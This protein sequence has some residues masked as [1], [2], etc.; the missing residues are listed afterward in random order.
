MPR[1]SSY[2]ED[3][4]DRLVRAAAERLVQAPPDQLSLRELAAS[5]DTSTNAIYSL[6]GGKDALIRAVVADANESFLAEQEKALE[7][8]ATI[9]G[10]ME[11]GRRYRAWALDQPSLY[12]LMFGGV[13]TLASIPC[14][15]IGP[16]EQMVSALVEAGVLRAAPVRSIGHALWAASHGFV[17][18]EMGLQIDREIGDEQFREFQELFLQGLLASSEEHALAASV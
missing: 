16:L 5:Q 2:P 7:F 14:Y 18:I 11:L 1:V 9:E 8:G 17:L 10:L 13:G 3:L 12:Q 15:G 4:R 6:F